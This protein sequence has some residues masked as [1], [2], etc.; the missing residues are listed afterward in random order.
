[1][2][3]KAPTRGEKTQKGIKITPPSDPLFLSLKMQNFSVLKTTT[4]KRLLN[5]GS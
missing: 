4:L 2:H 5:Q 1:M 3:K